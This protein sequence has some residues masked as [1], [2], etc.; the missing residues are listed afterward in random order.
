[1]SS[2][3]R[4]IALIALF[5]CLSKPNLVETDFVRTLLGANKEPENWLHIPE[6]PSVSA[7]ACSPDWV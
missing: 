3:V 7:I 5:G 1:M 2:R 6:L 4:L